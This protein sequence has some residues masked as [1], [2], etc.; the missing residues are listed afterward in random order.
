MNPARSRSTFLAL[1]M[2]GAGPALAEG[3]A[4]FYNWQNFGGQD[5]TIS[6]SSRE[7]SIS[8]SAPESALIRSGR[9][10][11]CTRPD[12]MGRCTVLPPGEYPKI[13][14]QFGHI[15]SARE[16]GTIPASEPDYRR[17]W[18]ERERRGWR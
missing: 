9:W 12:F 5:I 4:T 17:R 16:L 13:G 7:F 6:D 18:I 2:A 10:E 11:I 15:A 14:E 8:G 1:V 3:Q